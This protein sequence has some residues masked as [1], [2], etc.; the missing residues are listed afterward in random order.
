MV[1]NSQT[2]ICPVCTTSSVTFFAEIPQVPILCNELWPTRNQAL[3]APCGDLLLGF[4]STCGHIYN[5]AFDPELIAYTQKYENSLHF[6]PRFQAYAEALADR[7]I[8]RYN[9]HDKQIIEIGCGKGDFLAMICRRGPNTGIGFDPSYEPELQTDKSSASFKVVQDFYSEQ[10]ADHQADLICCRHVLE[11]IEYPREFIAMIRRSIGQG[12][13]PMVYF[14]VPNVM[15][16]LRDLAIWDLLYEHVSYFS[17]ASLAYLFRTSGFDV[18]DLSEAFGGQYLGIEASP[19]DHSEEIA[20][21]SEDQAQVHA[22]QNAVM[23]FSQR[24]SEK[25]KTWKAHLAAIAQAKQKA[26]IWGAGTKGV[27][28]SNI[29]KAQDQIPY[30]VDINPRKQGLYIAG[31]GQQ[32]VPPDFL[33]EYHPDVIIL[34]NPLYEQEVKDNVRSMGLTPQFLVA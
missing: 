19:N 34:M 33:R 4:C 8:D 32:I 6:S 24:Y 16:T 11:H 1:E 31:T 12:A 14:E 21:K 10:Y 18:L 20:S 3:E 7:L 15:A 22:L 5:Y 30:V 13:Q 25:V 29:L 9:L 17:E 28:I 2:H 23:S 26:V 27:T